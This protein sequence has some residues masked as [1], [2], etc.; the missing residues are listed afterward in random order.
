MA[1]AIVQLRAI[2]LS[3]DFDQYWPFHIKKDQERL[4][5]A[6][7]W[8]VPVNQRHK[9]IG[10]LGRRLKMPGYEKSPAFLSLGG[11]QFLLG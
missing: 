8:S 10:G 1:E 11:P 4:H 5:P 9:R 6:S 2:Y 3:A 7:R